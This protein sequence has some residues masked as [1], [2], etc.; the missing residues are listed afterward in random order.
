MIVDNKIE[1]Y[2]V[3]KDKELIKYIPTK[4]GFGAI[5]FDIGNT[6]IVF[7]TEDLKEILGG[8]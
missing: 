4:L 2:I 7:K 8:I 1:C 5:R 3:K 6:A